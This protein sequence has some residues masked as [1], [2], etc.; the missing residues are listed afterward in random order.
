MFSPFALLSM[1]VEVR[2]KMT[3]RKHIARIEYSDEDR[4]FIGH[5]ADIT[6][7]V[8][9]HGDSVPQLRTA[10]EEAVDD[11]LETCEKLKSCIHKSL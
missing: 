7:V 6:D 4:C 10:F 5:I 9:F 1:F 8:G 2:F 3:Y 11:Y